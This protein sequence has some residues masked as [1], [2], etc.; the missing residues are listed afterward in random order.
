MSSRNFSLTVSADIS[1]ETFVSALCGSDAVKYRRYEIVD[2]FRRD[3][4][5]GRYVL[6]ILYKFYCL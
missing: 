4:V 3:F 2:M 1:L 6:K 5:V